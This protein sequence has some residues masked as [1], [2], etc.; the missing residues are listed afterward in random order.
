[1]IFSNS[2][3]Q[4]VVS[5]DI[6]FVQTIVITKNI[7]YWLRIQKVQ[8]KRIVFCYGYNFSDMSHIMC[9]IFNVL[10]KLVFL[11]QFSRR[12][13]LNLPD[14][15]VMVHTCFIRYYYYYYLFLVIIY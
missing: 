12:T 7:Y 6:I 5:V 1:M 13:T 14:V 2:K 4:L 11:G 3:S 8:V 9:L 10:K 15:F